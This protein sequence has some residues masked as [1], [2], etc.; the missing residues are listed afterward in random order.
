MSDSG[1]FQKQSLVRL[2][3][4]RTIARS[5]LTGWDERMSIEW[6]PLGM[7]MGRMMWS[8]AQEEERGEEVPPAGS[9]WRG[10]W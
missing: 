5:S 6:A 2:S 7:M 10:G 9:Q 3:C 4:E 1:S 8:E